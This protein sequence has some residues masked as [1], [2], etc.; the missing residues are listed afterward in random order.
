MAMTPIIE[1]RRKRMLTDADI[2]ALREALHGDI[3]PAEHGRHHEAIRAWIERE[4]RKAERAEK[5][6]TQIMG[7]TFISIL[8]ALGTGAVQAA[9]YLRDHLK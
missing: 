1:N 8:A 4:N 6:K 9:N 7:W 5:I 2:D 3:D